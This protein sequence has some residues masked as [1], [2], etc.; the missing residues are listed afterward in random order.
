MRAAT[1]LFALMPAKRIL[2]RGPLVARL[3]NKLALT[4]RELA[5]KMGVGE[6]RLAHI[7][8]RD[9]TGVYAETFRN[10]AAAV[11]MSIDD[12]RREVG[13]AETEAR[14]KDWEA[15]GASVLETLKYARSHDAKVLDAK[16]KA[17]A[18]KSKPENWDSNVEPYSEEAVPEIPFFDLSLAAGTWVDIAEMGQVMDAK[19]YAHGRFR[20]RIRGDSMAPGYKDG[21]IVE[22]QIAVFGRDVLY[23]GRDYYFQHYDG[24]GT[25]KRLEKATETHFHLRP[26][27]KK[28]Y[29]ELM[30]VEREMICRMARARYRVEEI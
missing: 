23:V 13:V 15:G 16:T 17:F 6:T 25:F 28:K 10:L 21:D 22:F 2:I 18:T 20:V 12:L 29:P 19:L 1:V 24:T 27:N 5:A 26:L 4:Q 30:K 3:R 8:Q 9:E 7:E 14:Q 11:E